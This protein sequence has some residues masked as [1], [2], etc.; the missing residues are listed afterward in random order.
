ML[1][2]VLAE[3]RRQGHPNSS[4]PAVT[5]EDFDVLRTLGE[6]GFGKVLLVRKK[7]AGGQHVPGGL[8]AMKVLKKSFIV[9]TGN[10]TRSIA[11]HDILAMVHH[12]FIVELHFAFQSEEHLFLVLNYVGGGELYTL[13]ESFHGFRSSGVPI[14]WVQFYSA[15]MAL[16]RL[17]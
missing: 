14:D 8:Y 2:R 3:Q 6:G 10:V 1:G 9:E 16:A 17:R 7:D 12:P 11:E 5:H 15:V 13:M 4:S